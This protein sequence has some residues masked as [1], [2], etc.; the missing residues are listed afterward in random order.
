MKQEL[1]LSLFLMLLLTLLTACID[2]AT[3][4]ELQDGYYTDTMLPPL[5]MIVMYSF[6]PWLN[7][8]A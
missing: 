8:A 3:G 4:T 6:Q 2:K 7:S 1:R 5:T